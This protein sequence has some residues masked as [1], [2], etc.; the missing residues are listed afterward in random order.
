MKQMWDDNKYCL[1]PHSA[2]AVH[3]ANTVAKDFTD[4]TVCVLTAHPAKFE[5]AVMA[6]IGV[7]PPTVP[8]VEK[9]KTM[10]HKFTWLRMPETGEVDIDRPA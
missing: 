10:P 1:C 3:A 7:L 5:E 2:I 6:A 9:M 4:P 8:V